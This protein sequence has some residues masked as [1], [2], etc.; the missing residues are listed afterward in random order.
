[1][2]RGWRGS[3]R[4]RPPAL[5]TEARS[6]RQ[7]A[8]E[9]ENT[10]LSEAID[11]P[12]LVEAKLGSIWAD[13]AREMSVPTK[14][15]PGVTT[16]PTPSPGN[17]VVR[18]NTGSVPPSSRFPHAHETAQAPQQ[19]GTARA[20]CSVR[21]MHVPVTKTG[22]Q[23]AVIECE[24]A[25]AIET[26]S[27][28]PISQERQRAVDRPWAVVPSGDPT[29]TCPATGTTPSQDPSLAGRSLIG[30]ARAPAEARAFLQ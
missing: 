27:R 26:A 29:G 23:P 30:S 8:A 9:S 18:K 2:A 24:P 3:T 11:E 13:F 16:S 1:M 4:G 7:N 10:A 17:V 21:F 15:A 12:F 28:Q 5:L 20:D 14:A 19:A 6:A 25:A 22:H